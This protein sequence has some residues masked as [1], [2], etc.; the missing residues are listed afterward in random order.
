MSC[1]L[2]GCLASSAMRLFAVERSDVAGLSLSAGGAFCVLCSYFYLQPLSDALALQVGIALTP[3]ITVANIIVI[4]V[5]NAFYAILVKQRPV[6]SVLPL[7][8]FI[9]MG[10]LVVF[11]GFF[12]FIPGL[13]DSEPSPPPSPESSPVSPPPLEDASNLAPPSL[14]LLPMLLSFGFCVFTGTVSL[15]LTTTF[16]A[17]MASLHTKEEAK[18]VYGVIA[19]GAQVGQLAASISAPFLFMILQKRIVLCSAI[20]LAVAVRLVRLRGSLPPLIETVASSTPVPKPEESA[21]SERSHSSAGLLAKCAQPLEGVYVLMSTPL[22]RAITAQTLLSTF[23]VSGIWY[24]RLVAVAAAFTSEEEQ[25]SF[26]ATMN[27]VVGCLS[28]FA[29]LFLFSHVLKRV[30]FHGAMVAEPIVVV[31]GLI[32]NCLQ[33]GLLSISLLDGGRKVVH[34]ALAKPTKEGLY[35]AMPADA[36]FVAKPL[37][38]TFVYRIG[39]L[40][41]ASYFAASSHYAS[42]R[43]YF[44]LSV[45][46]VWGMNSYYVGIC[47]ERQQAA[48]ETYRACESTLGEQSPLDDE[49]LEHAALSASDATRSRC[50]SSKGRGK[51]ERRATG[52]RF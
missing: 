15:F 40:I 7:V 18:R 1:D 22:L 32:I 12:T 25:Y 29:Q 49:A 28:L 19:A 4:I 9:I 39:S 46:I 14:P 11:A 42:F 23:L 6:A 51:D 21:D 31:C 30:G 10:S 24:E 38:D 8:Y 20:L 52:A 13:S 48:H 3:L 47:A 17:R 35:S 41:G 5:L 2:N 50:Q 43:R 34:Y 33:P 16:W 44:L 45:T 36:Q 26:F 27:S 37:L